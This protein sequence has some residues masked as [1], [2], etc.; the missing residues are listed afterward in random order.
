MSKKCKEK[1]GE[2]IKGSK[3]LR[4]FCIECGEPMRVPIERLLDCVCEKCN[5]KDNS[6]PKYTLKELEQEGLTFHQFDDRNYHDE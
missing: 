4:G 2:R 1:L 6:N 5:E 3:Y